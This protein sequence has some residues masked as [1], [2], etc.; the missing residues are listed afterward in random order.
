MLAPTVHMAP[1]MSQSLLTDL[2]VIA[3]ADQAR[4]SE[5]ILR[6]LH[7]TGTAVLEVIRRLTVTAGEQRPDEDRLPPV[8]LR[9]LDPRTPL[10]QLAALAVLEP[11]AIVVLR[12][13]CAAERN[14]HVYVGLSRL[15]RNERGAGIAVD[16]LVT[17]AEAL[18]IGELAV[19]AALA[20]AGALVRNGL[21]VG[22]DS[23]PTLG[24][25][26]SVAERVLEHV[27]DQ[28]D[29]PPRDLPLVREPVHAVEE[30]CLGDSDP[31]ELAAV[32]RL[33]HFLRTVER[34]PVWVTGP[35]GVGRRTLVAAVAAEQHLN[36]MCLD[37]RLVRREKV[38]EMIPAL[39]REV[40]L[41][42]ALILIHD[43][44]L[45]DENA[46][47]MQLYAALGRAGLPVVFTSSE[48][49]AL[50]DFEVPPALVALA[51][52]AEKARIQMWRELLPACDGLEP[53]ASRFRLTPGRIHRLAL[54]AAQRADLAGRAVNA[55]DVAHAVSRSVGQRV[56]TLGTKVEH[57]QSWDDVVLPDETMDAVREMVSRVRCRHRVLEE[58]GFQKKV[59]KGTGVVS[60][61]AG[62]P[63]TGK[64]MVAG[65][66]A[67]ELGV[68]LYQIDLS[69]VVS[70][71]VGETEKN[72]GRVFD[73]AEGANVML[74]FDEADS[75]FAKRTEVKSSHDRHSNGEV[76]YLLQRVERFEGVCVLT[77]NL[78]GSIDQA[79][80]RRIAFRINFPMPD[81]AERATLWK[82]L[83]PAQAAVAADVD[84]AALARRYE[85]SGGRIRNAVLRAAFLAASEDTVIGMGHLERAVTLEYR[86]AGSLSSTGKLA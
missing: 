8:R 50:G 36:T 61:F 29:R 4:A 5:R 56:S 19:L 82:R 44:E 76:N 39:W 66:I 75:L 14:H 7:A 86:D 48:A 33:R 21:V 52:P 85:L 42:Q 65:L 84:F 69:R 17:V 15:A 60:L 68:E 10:G 18:G 26:L 59:A 67:R 70:K 49:P 6:E 43:V 58:W 51:A 41:G 25:K 57:A 53:L 63:G 80:R 13:L 1:R 22:A 47:A 74:L 35:Q 62:P 24:C 83:M 38:E 77:T 37:Y 78:E 54:D 23:G 45:G 28:A 30:L 34:R 16:A 32:D 20:P 79:F 9:L 27:V 2:D 72:L 64:T 81:A 31:D 11:A 12:V 3:S 46:A 40:L 73:A 55:A 71:Y